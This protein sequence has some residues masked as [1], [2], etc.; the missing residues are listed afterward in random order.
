QAGFRVVFIPFA[1]GQPTGEWSTF[2]IDAESATGLRA[3]G[4]AVAPDGAV[5][6]TSDQAGKVWRVTRAR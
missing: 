3:A 4:V 2:A 6:I 5:Y 1:N